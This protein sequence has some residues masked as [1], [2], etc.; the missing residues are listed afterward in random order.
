M[1][2]PKT[3]RRRKALLREAQRAICERY[4]EFDLSLADIA[5]D[6]GCSTRQLQRVFREL[7]GEDF[8]GYLLQVRM[9]QVHRLL[10]KRT[11]LSIR[12]TAPL[13]GYRAANGLR[14]AFLRFY[15]YTP[16]IIQPEPPEFL[17]E[18]DEPTTVLPVDL[19]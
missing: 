11:G 10:R 16:S 1:A 14:Q 18:M 19:D 15:G 5:A 3:E 13:V 8:R 2:Q 7:A 17:G 4:S 12:A 9:E 6:V